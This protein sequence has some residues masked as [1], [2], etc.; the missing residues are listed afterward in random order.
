MTRGR[1]APWNRAGQKRGLRSG[2]AARHSRPSTG[3]GLGMNANVVL[4]DARALRQRL[5]DCA[6]ISFQERETSRTLQ[7]WLTERGLE[8][9][10]GLAGTGLLVDVRAS[11]EGP[12]R[13][14]RAD[15]DA[16]GTSAGAHEVNLGFRLARDVDGPEA[17]H[18]C[19]H[20][21]HAAMLAGALMA[22]AA[23]PDAWSGRVI[24][25]FQPA[26]EVGR[27]AKA[28]LEHEELRSLE[29]DQAFAIH[30][31]PGLPLGTLGVANG[32]AALASTGLV[33][34]LTG[35]G[36]H[37][38]TPHKGNAAIAAMATFIRELLALPSFVVPFGSSVLITPTYLDAGKRQFGRVPPSG[39]LGVVIRGDSDECL[40]TVLDAARRRVDTLAEAY[41]L[42]ASVEQ[43]EPFPTT[44]NDHAVVQH[45]EQV[46][47]AV[48]FDVVIRDGAQIGR[49]HV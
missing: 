21:G 16:I 5:H 47:Q 35:E 41:F 10:A 13:L 31:Q 45:V 49:A 27:G 37:A 8:V 9:T 22:L 32:V 26:E 2:H 12:T 23:R 34:R 18:V 43:V 44:V 15:I 33:I 38:S 29:V 46:L 40:A 11:R 28:M 20:D 4:S 30:N 3:Y 19:G 42:Q 7:Q 1:R 36:T 39:E 48:G 17:E 25:V 14:F 24:G 6:E